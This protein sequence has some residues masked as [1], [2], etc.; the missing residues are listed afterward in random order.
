MF[1]PFSRKDQFILIVVER[2][3]MRDYFEKSLPTLCG[4]RKNKRCLDSRSL[5]GSDIATLSSQSL[6]RY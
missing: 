3:V 5:V 1:L 6:H 2:K 4:I